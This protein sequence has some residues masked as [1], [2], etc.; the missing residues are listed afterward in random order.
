MGPTQ[1]LT[2]RENV[3]VPTMGDFRR[4]ARTGMLTKYL[5]IDFT[6]FSDSIPMLINSEV[7][8]RV[9]GVLLGYHDFLE[10]IGDAGIR[11]DYPRLAFKRWEGQSVAGPGTVGKTYIWAYTGI[12]MVAA[13]LNSTTQSYRQ[14]LLTEIHQVMQ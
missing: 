14:D 11:K 6:D 3:I 1:A 2:T 9:S 8:Q 5:N 7:Y 4:L 13:S 10:T 12:V